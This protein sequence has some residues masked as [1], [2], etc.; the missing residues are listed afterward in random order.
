[1]RWKEN[2]ESGTGIKLPNACKAKR[3]TMNNGQR[4]PFLHRV[5]KHQVMVMMDIAGGGGRMFYSFCFFSSK[6]VTV[7]FCLAFLYTFP[8]LS[9]SPFI[10]NKR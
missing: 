5:L 1:M 2:F 9:T 7:F 3:R 8:P 10:P 4:G 6:V